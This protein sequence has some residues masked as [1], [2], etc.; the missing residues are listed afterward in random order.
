MWCLLC[1]TLV[2]GTQGQHVPC[3]TEHPNAALAAIAQGRLQFDAAEECLSRLSPTEVNKKSE[4]CAARLR[5]ASQ[6]HDVGMHGEAIRNAEHAVQGCAGSAANHLALAMHYKANQSHLM[7]AQHIK[8]A[9]GLSP[10]V[11]VSAAQHY[12]PSVYL[13]F[14]EAL[15]RLGLPG[16]AHY[17][18]LG[19][20]P[21]RPLHGSL[22]N[23]EQLV[24]SASP[25]LSL[26][27][28]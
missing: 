14:G 4:V 15:N 24:R 21:Q 22:D 1:L 13:Y 10:A 6:F 16:A 8:V 12:G 9:L 3:S 27:H 18:G 7:A 5:V 28:I 19:S 11:L 17:Y 25:Q 23:P 2:I 26:I 20:L